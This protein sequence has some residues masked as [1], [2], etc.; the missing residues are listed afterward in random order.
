MQNHSAPLVLASTSPR[1]RELVTLFNAAFQFFAADID[2][3]PREDE[4]PADLVRRLSRAKA[5]TAARDF[6]N[7]RVISADTIVWLNRTIIGKPQD[8]ADAT[9]ML[10]LLRARPHVV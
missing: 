9:R 3:S 6:S 10:K 8:T 1:R 5:E 4:S 2:E 7:A